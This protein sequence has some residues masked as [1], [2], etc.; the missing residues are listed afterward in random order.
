LNLDGGQCPPYWR[1]QTEIIKILNKAPF[2]IDNFNPQQGADIKQLQFVV[3]QLH[4]N[5]KFISGS[6]EP[7]AFNALNKRGSW[8]AMLGSNSKESP[9]HYVIIDGMKGD[10][11]LI[12]DHWGLVA[13]GKGRGLEAEWSISKFMEAWNLTRWSVVFPDKK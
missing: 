8:I 13:P 12:R 10:N 9:N 2:G 7:E 11:V 1:D 4:P 6:V 5:S 3:N